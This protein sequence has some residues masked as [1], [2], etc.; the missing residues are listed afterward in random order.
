MAKNDNANKEL[1]NTTG[2]ATVADNGN[3]RWSLSKEVAAKYDLNWN[4]GHTVVIGRF[5]QVDLRTVTLAKVEQMVEKGVVI[6]K[7]R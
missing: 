2:S 1:A 4:G 7:K 5:G 6:F 3:K